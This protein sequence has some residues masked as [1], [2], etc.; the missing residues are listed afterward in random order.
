MKMKSNFK[1]YTAI[2]CLFF[3][4]IANGQFKSDGKGKFKVIK[5]KLT[6]PNYKV[7]YPK[8]KNKKGW[9][10]GTQ[11]AV[12]YCT[13]NETE[14]EPLLSNLRS[15]DITLN[16]FYPELISGRDPNN[17]PC[18]LIVFGYGGGF[19]SPY[20]SAVQAPD[21]VIQRYYASLGYIVVAPEYRIGIDL[22]DKNLCERAIWR[23]VQDIRKTIRYS[24]NLYNATKYKVDATKSVVY[25]GYSSG[26]FIGLHNLYLNDVLSINGGKR[27][28]TTTGDYDVCFHK[29][30][31]KE[32]SVCINRK[33]YNLGQL[34]C[35]NGID[36]ELLTP[37]EKAKG[38]PDI[39]IILAGAIGNLNWINTKITQSLYLIQSDDDGVVPARTG[40]AY[41]NFKLFQDDEFDYP[42]VSGCRAI[43]FRFKQNPNFKP[44]KYKYTYIK[45]TCTSLDGTN[46][47]IGDAGTEIGPLGYKTWNHAPHLNKNKLN[48]ALMDS[49]VK[50]IQ[51]NTN[52]KNL[53]NNDMN[54][55][56]EF[57]LE[58]NST[59]F[60]LFPNPVMDN[61]LNILGM[62]E[63]EVL[64]YQVFTAQGQKVDAGTVRDNS[65]DVQELPNGFYF[66]ELITS[67][68]TFKKQF[69][70]Q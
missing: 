2:A 63:Q 13:S 51:I 25:I 43:D 23:A 7:Y 36:C 19:L 62:N 15:K 5:E 37:E 29:H 11:D 31:N 17:Y 56:V 22:L 59:E 45:T 53:R 32:S 16:V 26:G 47:M 68:G 60:T 21:E 65:I 12:L 39:S 14:S 61:T 6:I 54:E 58:S 33:T 35:P 8:P 69:I 70:K 41:K 42:T 27:P 20:S 9:G 67:R 49:I 1:I 64:S 30:L 4:I 18:Q 55:S 24:R 34:D 38:I 3:F 66:I 10:L 48:S 52:T 57:E 40:F 28:M 46:C 44:D 50:F